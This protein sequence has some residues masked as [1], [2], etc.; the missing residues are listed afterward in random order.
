MKGKNT[1]VLFSGGMDSYVATLWA[2]DNFE[3]VTLLFVDYGQNHI[4]EKVQALKIA[5]SLHLDLVV[6]TTTLLGDIITQGKLVTGDKPYVHNRNALLLTIAHTYATSNHIYSI[7]GGMC[8]ED[9]TG[10]PDCREEYLYK[11][12]DCL[13]MACE[14]EIVLSTP[15]LHLSKADTYLMAKG[16]N[17]LVEVLYMTHTCY[18][19]IREVK[20]EWGYGCG[21]CPS[22]IVRRNGW[23]E[24]KGGL[25]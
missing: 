1:V 5:A 2:R 24:Y 10:F 7:I 14:E 4:I 11:F 19:G 18:E 8:Q 16:Y 25:V 15:I 3:R 9:E 13:N 22:C 20:H 12:I 6:I 21:T 17:H 23:D